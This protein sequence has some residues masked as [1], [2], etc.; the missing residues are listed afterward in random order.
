MHPTARAMLAGLT[1]LGVR[2]VAQAVDGGL[3]VIQEVVTDVSAEA[4]ARIKRTRATAQS[5]GRVD[6]SGGAGVGKAKPR[7]V[8]VDVVGIHGAEVEEEE[9]E[10][11]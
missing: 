3:E 6:R 11:T 7:Y 2:V 1:R 9:E 10:T 8:K 4:A 5:I